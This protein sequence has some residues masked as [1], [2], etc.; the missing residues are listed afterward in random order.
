MSIL[1]D[2][3]AELDFIIQRGFFPYLAYSIDI[4]RMDK[5]I[6]TAPSHDHKVDP[7]FL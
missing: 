7:T 1:E 4:N 2:G 3:G 5:I 6:E